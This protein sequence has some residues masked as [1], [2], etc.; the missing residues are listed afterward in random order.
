MEQMDTE[1]VET[2]AGVVRLLRRAAELAWIEADEGGPRSS[3]QLLA[4]GIDSAAD[5]GAWLLPRRARLDGPTPVGQ[6]PAEF[7]ASAEQLLRRI[8]VVGAPPGLLGLRALVAELIWE[9]I[10]VPAR[11]RRTVGE[12]LADSDALSRETLLDVSASQ[13]PAMVRTWGQVVQSAA[14]LWAALPPISVAAP[15]GPDLMVRLRVVGTALRA[16]LRLVAAW[17]GSCG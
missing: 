1:V 15:S 3:R 2:V 17:S 10:P 5:E 7:L 8:C 11:D 16:A 13:G 14:R 6:D 12:L 4:L 9:P